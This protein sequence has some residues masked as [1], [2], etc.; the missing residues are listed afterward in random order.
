MLLARLASSLRPHSFASSALR[1]SSTGYN[2]VGVGS[3]S[4]QLSTYSLLMNTPIV[5]KGVGDL[6]DKYDCFL[7]D[8]FGVLHDG[9]NPLP[10]VVDALEQLQA[11]GKVCIVL[12]NSS[13]RAASAAKKFEK[14]GLPPVYSAF[15]T[16][17]ELAW[18]YMRANDFKGKKCAWIT[19]G[20]YAKDDY[21]ASLEVAVADVEQADFLLLHGTHC[22]AAPPGQEAARC[23]V[24]STGVI[25]E[26][27]QR[28]LEVAARRGLPCVCANDDLLAVADG[29][30]SHMPGLLKKEYLR[31]GGSVISFGK[32][33][34]TMFDAAMAAA[35]IT[36]SG[37]AGSPL[38][39]RIVH[40]GDSLTHDIS[41]AHAAGIDSL[42]VTSK[43]VHKHELVEVAAQ[44]THV[45]QMGEAGAGAVCNQGSSPASPPL[46]MQV[47]D[48][49]DREQTPRPT[50]IVRNFE[51]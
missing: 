35:Q 36:L 17:G 4:R 47:C 30:L 2:R 20:G 6:A 8:Q 32:P 15:L 39:R 40:V 7:L 42:L 19:W 5:T 29:K 46:L 23:S 48:L 26:P 45:A 14:L 51:W 16:S 28:V 27:M 33:S 10:G 43:G 22:V 50:Y 11:R 34:S 9:A 18:Q 3:T 37:A 12:S 49:C 31:L 44:V 24:F 41:G 38:E 25:D 21:L 13:S 1:R